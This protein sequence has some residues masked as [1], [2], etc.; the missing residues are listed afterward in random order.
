MTSIS[1]VTPHTIMMATQGMA[2]IE[3]LTSATWNNISTVA[4]MNATEPTLENMLTNAFGNNGFTPGRPGK[5]TIK[6]NAAILPRVNHC[7]VV[8]G[9]GLGA[10]SSI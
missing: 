1:T 8:K 6:I 7:F 3:A 4:S 2:R 9:S 5:T 10:I